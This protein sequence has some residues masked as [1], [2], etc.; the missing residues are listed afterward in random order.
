MGDDKYLKTGDEVTV[1]GFPN[2]TSGS[3][4]HVCNGQITSQKLLF[5]KSMDYKCGY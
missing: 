3:T 4:P 1:V 2:F 5:E